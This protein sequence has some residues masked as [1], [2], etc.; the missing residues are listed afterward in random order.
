MFMVQHLMWQ[1]I[2]I[3]FQPIIL[4][5]PIQFSNEDYVELL[6][7]RIPQHFLS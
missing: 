1:F 3:S 7:C 6:G 4:G 2:Y 5:F